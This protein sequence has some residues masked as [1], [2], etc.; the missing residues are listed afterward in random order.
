LAKLGDPRAVEAL[1]HQITDHPALVEEETIE[2][3]GE[4]G[5]A[6]SIPHLANYLNSLRSQL[7]RAAARALAK[8]GDRSAIGALIEAA[9][10]PN[11]PDLRRATLQALRVLE[12]REAED[13][14]ADSLLDTHPSVRIAAAEAVAELDLRGTAPHLRQSL[15]WFDDEA[16]SEVA[17]ALGS[18][19]DPSDL[20]L[21]LEAAEKCSSIITR[22]RCLLG[23]ARLLRVEH[24]VY[25]LLLLEGMSRDTA[26]LDL[27]KT[28]LKGNK[29][30][31]LAL[32]QFSAGQEPEA[33]QLICEGKHAALLQP[34]ADHPVDELFLVAAC[35]VASDRTRWSI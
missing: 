34:L 5:S 8:I 4:L 11:D 21:I 16:A 2:A 1:I 24:E 29:R 9:R 33:L 27:L 32:D 20:P 35:Y 23:V 13:V 28:H 26:V 7:R 10:R 6:E 19:G 12:A 30:L 17:Y 3:L 31:R 15:E 14:I 22:R 25:R 18:V